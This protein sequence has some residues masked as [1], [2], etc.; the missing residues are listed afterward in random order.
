LQPGLH[1]R[2]VVEPRVREFVVKFPAAAT[3]LGVLALL[4]T[5]PAAE[6]LRNTNVRKCG[7]FQNLARLLRT[8]GVDSASELRAWLTEPAS[9]P[10]LLV[11]HGV[12]IKTAA[13]LRLLVGLP[14][15]AIDIHL[16]R[17]AEAVGVTRSD[18][19]LERLYTAAAANIGVDLAELDGSLWQQG[20][21]AR[22]RGV[23]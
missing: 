17:A 12:G 8:E 14:S 1:Y 9:R 21:D 5:R 18:E 13:Y 2:A 23:T 10:K 20:A 16:R 4:E 6:L 3:V 22:Q 11:L 7:V 19:D 15:I